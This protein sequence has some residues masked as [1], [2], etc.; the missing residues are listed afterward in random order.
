MKKKVDVYQAVCSVFVE[1]MHK[2][3]MEIKGYESLPF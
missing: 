2:S 3:Q 1:Y